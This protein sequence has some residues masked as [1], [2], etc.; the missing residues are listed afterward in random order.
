MI[1]IFN[2]FIEFKNES[3]PQTILGTAPLTGEAYFGHRA[4]LYQLDLARNP[5]NIAE[6]ILDS[7]DSGVKAIN[8]VNDEALLNGF[9]IACDNGCK[10][11]IIATIAKRDV[12]YLNPD[13]ESSKNINYHE[14]IEIFESL[15][16]KVMLIDEFIVDSY[17]W[18]LIE[19]I[20]D[21]I[22]KISTSGLIT[23]FPFKTTSKIIEADF[24]K[25][26]F[27]FYMIP[28]NQLSYMMDSPTFLQKERDELK[29]L[30]NKLDKKIIASKVLAA[31]I[32]MP[33][34]A[35]NFI[36][37]L[38]YIDLLTIGVANKKE[39]EEDFKTLFKI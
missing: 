6:I 21:D 13:Y 22:N 34:E 2:D 28:I 14:D 17:D 23:A 33:N 38:D 37:K 15:S 10:M 20:L 11:D 12:D 19:N 8:L 24:N 18:N 35:F 9:Q 1:L 29:G 32:Q 5:Q 25:S 26:L 7:Y 16:S 3:I 4:R 27:D 30:L 36:K 39:V 31:G